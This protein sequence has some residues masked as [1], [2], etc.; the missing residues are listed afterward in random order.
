M[1]RS[2]TRAD[3]DIGDGLQ[4]YFT[5]ILLMMCFGLVLTG[6]M[7]WWISHDPAV[8]QALFHLQPVV[9]AKGETVQMPAMSMWWV[10]SA[11]LQLAIVVLLSVLGLGESGLPGWVSTPVFGIYALLSGV[12]LAPALYAYTDVSIAKVAM[13]TAA[14]FGASALWGKTTKTDLRGMGTFFLMALWGLLFVLIVNIF[15]SSPLMDFMVSGAAVLLFAGLT[16]YD[17]Q[18]LEDLY[19]ESDSAGGPVV[20]GALVLYLDV[21]NLFLHLLRLFGTKK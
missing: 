6:G 4:R 19:D 7:A 9:N 17:M 15:F 8:M 18:R 11:L 3:G 14:T 21:I 13:I 20:Y 5:N 2:L 1:D 16:A 12:T 10:A